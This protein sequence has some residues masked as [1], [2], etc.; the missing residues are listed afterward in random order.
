VCGLTRGEDVKYSS[1]AAKMH[2]K[3][4]EMKLICHRAAAGKKKEVSVEEEK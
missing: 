3:M 4:K 1:Q 2:L